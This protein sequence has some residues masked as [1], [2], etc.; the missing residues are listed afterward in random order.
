MKKRNPNKNLQQHESGIWYVQMKFQR[1]RFWRSTGTRSIEEARAFR[2]AFQ[3]SLRAGRIQRL[4][5]SMLR[6]GYVTIGELVTAYLVEAQ[7]R[8]SP[9][10]ETARN[11]VAALR[12]VVAC[13]GDAAAADSV[14]TTVLTDELVKRYVASAVPADGDMEE[15]DRRRRSAASN[16]RQARCVLKRNM[17]LAYKGLSLPDVA[18]FVTAYACESPRVE[19]DDFA[20]EEI[21]ML[22]AGSKLKG[23]RDDLYAVWLLGYHLALRAG[24]MAAARWSWITPAGDHHEMHVKRRPEEGYDPKGYSGWVP[25]HAAVYAELQALR[26][27]GDEYILPG[28][29]EGA[30]YDL[31]QRDFSEWMR[32]R[33]WRRRHCAHELRAYAGQRW[34]KAYGELVRRDWMRHSDVKVGRDHYVG[35]HNVSVPPLA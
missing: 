20:V 22:E 4:G 35:N 18:G 6:G 13:G 21:E 12:R 26:R 1:R 32:G 29:T 9:R 34:E 28:G 24:E 14:S 23:V 30:R 33:G 15:M 11:N 19:R 25:V 10:P 16:L 3:K 7:R 27:P 2:D 31:V 17:L 8:G 5:E